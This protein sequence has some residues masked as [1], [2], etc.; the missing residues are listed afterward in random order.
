MAGRAGEAAGSGGGRRE[1]EEV[2]VLH[3]SKATRERRREMLK[4]NEE[5]NVD[6]WMRI[7][8]LK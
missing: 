3:V 7:Q 6:R 4:R 2:V 1:W 8:C 5:T